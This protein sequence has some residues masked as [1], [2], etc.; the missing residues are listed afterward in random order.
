MAEEVK[1]PA[2]DMPA[3]IVSCIAIVTV[4]YVIMALSLVMMVPYKQIDAAAAFAAAFQVRKGGGVGPGGSW[5][6]CEREGR[7]GG[8]RKRERGSK[9]AFSERSSTCSAAFANTRA[10]ASP[11]HRSRSATPRTRKQTR[12]TAGMPWMRVV[13]AIGALLGIITGVLVGVMAVARIFSAVGRAHLV[14]P[15]VGHVHK[16][17]ALLGLLS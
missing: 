5:R 12:Q 17:C 3:G 13:V 6:G 10:R 15:V 14:F 16:R 9:Q 11:S 4:I 7:G 2:R 8:R 1:K